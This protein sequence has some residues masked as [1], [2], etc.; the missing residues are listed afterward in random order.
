MLPIEFKNVLFAINAMREFF[1]I[2]D[3]RLLSYLKGYEGGMHVA[4]P[5]Y[6]VL[7]GVYTG[8]MQIEEYEHDRYRLRF[9]TIPVLYT[10]NPKYETVHTALRNGL[11]IADEW[12]V[13]DLFLAWQVV[14]DEETEVWKYTDQQWLDAKYTEDN[15]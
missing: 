14:Y 13:H 15:L 8:D 5:H 12:L 10:A 1:V 6:P 7:H 3:Y 11:T 9:T 2:D 4:V